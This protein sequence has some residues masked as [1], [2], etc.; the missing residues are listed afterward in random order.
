MELMAAIIQNRTGTELA[1]I[2][3][4]SMGVDPIRILEADD[5]IV[6]QKSTISLSLTSEVDPALYADAIEASACDGRPAGCTLAATAAAATRRGLDTRSSASDYAGSNAR[7]YGRKLQMGHS[8]A[9]VSLTIS[10]PLGSAGTLGS[11]ASE[12]ALLTSALT[13]SASAALN[14]SA[15]VSTPLGTSFTVT[16]TVSMTGSGLAAQDNFDINSITLSIANELGVDV[17]TIGLSQPDYI[18]PPMPPPSLPPPP[19]PSP[20]P[21]PPGPPARPPPSPPLPLLPPWLPPFPPPPLPPTEPS[22]PPPPSPTQPEPVPPPSPPPSAP[23]P[24]PSSPPKASPSPLPPSS[25]AALTAE[26]GSV[27]MTAMAIMVLPL[28]LCVAVGFWRYRII[29]QRLRRAGAEHTGPSTQAATIAAHANYGSPDAPRLSLPELAEDQ[30]ATW[31]ELEHYRTPTKSGP[32]S[33]TLN[34]DYL[35]AQLTT[36]KE[37][38][39]LAELELERRIEELKRE[40]ASVRIQKVARGLLQRCEDA[41]QSKTATIMQ[42]SGRSML[43]QAAVVEQN[44]RTGPSQ[45]ATPSTSWFWPFGSSDDLAKPANE[46]PALPLAPPSTPSTPWL[47]PFGS[48]DDSTRTSGAPAAVAS[49]LCGAGAVAGGAEAARTRYDSLTPRTGAKAAQIASI[50]SLMGAIEKRE[51]DWTPVPTPRLVKEASGRGGSDGRLDDGTPPH[52]GVSASTARVMQ[53]APTRTPRMANA[54]EVFALVTQ[55]H[56]T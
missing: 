30:N 18:F 8:T 56:T 9:A 48:S 53:G 23:S 13:S 44:E 10:F 24:A 21:V 34:A 2:L 40:L 1:G 31:P 51:S 29:L 27:N 45:S 52:P 46:E 37:H 49:A 26:A 17:S 4:T 14:Q 16:L 50:S 11:N 55:R 42:R 25:L 19:P 15:S 28:L 32:D 54:Q 33:V 47:W 6:M 38:K 7:S 3:L 20:S 39:R 5:V 35:L 22:P 12:D 36:E 41:R 43:A